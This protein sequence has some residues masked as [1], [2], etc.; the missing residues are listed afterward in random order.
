MDRSWALAVI[1]SQLLCASARAQ[2]DCPGCAGATSLALPFTAAANVDPRTAFSFYYLPAE[3]QIAT[4]ADVALG[5]RISLRAGFT[6]VE[7][8]TLYRPTVGIR[9]Q[10]LAQRSDG[11]DAAVGTFYE[12]LGYEGKPELQA[13]L[14]VGRRQGRVGLVVN[15]VYGQETATDQR[16]GEVDM[17][18]L[19]HLTSRAAAGVDGRVAFDLDAGR[20]DEVADRPYDVTTGPVLSYSLGGVSVTAQSGL[21]AFGLRQARLVGGI[22]VG[23]IT[24]VF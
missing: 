15:L 24:G 23:G 10:L 14:A 8:G 1:G 5:R 20:D 3:G 9:V 11:I 18:V 2:P 4:R 21:N 13:R 7:P 12:S 17:A 16:H 6:N 22:V 19:Y